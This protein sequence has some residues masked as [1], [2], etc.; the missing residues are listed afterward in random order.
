LTKEGVSED[1]VKRA[2]ERVQKLTDGF[3][4]KIETIYTAKEQDVMSV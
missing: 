3:V 1:E 4:A 2:E